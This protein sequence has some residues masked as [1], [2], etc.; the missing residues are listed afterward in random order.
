M[1]KKLFVEGLVMDEFCDQGDLVRA[2]NIML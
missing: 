1:L 2:L